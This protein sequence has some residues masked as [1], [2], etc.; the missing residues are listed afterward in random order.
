MKRLLAAIALLLAWSTAIAAINI[1]TATREQLESLPG[2]GPVKAQAVIDYRNANGPFKSAEDI[3]KVKGIKEGEFGKIRD[4]ISVTGTTSVPA[5]PKGES[6][7][8]AGPTSGAAPAKT[9]AP[10]APPTAAVPAAATPPAAG[11]PAKDAG[12]AKMSKADEEKAAKAR[13]KEEKAAKAK[14]D[15]EAKAKAKE[16]Q[17][18]KTKEEK[19]AKASKDAAA[20]KDKAAAK[21]PPA[22][23]DGKDEKAKK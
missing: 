22:K 23:T 13:A 5:M 19:M 11:A 3:M 12:A 14:A 7:K 21:E 15:K 2:I 16:E 9:A 18:A 6:A 20:A 8:S 4:Q 1:N 10:A 17:A